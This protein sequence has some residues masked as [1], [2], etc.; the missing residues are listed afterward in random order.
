NAANR[1]RKFAYVLTSGVRP[2]YVIKRLRHRGDRA[3]VAGNLQ[4]ALSDQKF[5]GTVHAA[6]HHLCHLASAFLV[7]PHDKAVAVSVDGFGDF[8]SA[9]W[10]LGEGGRLSVD[11]RVYFPHSLG[12]FYEAMTQFIGFPHYGDE[13]KVMGLAP[14]GEPKFVREMSGLVEI[15]NN[16]KFKLDLRYFQHHTTNVSY[17]WNNCAPEVGKLYRDEMAELLGPPRNPEEPLEQRHK[18][19]ARSAQIVYEEAFFALLLALHRRYPVPN[20]ALSGGCA[21]NS[22]ANGKVYLRT[23]FRKMYLPAA[24]GDD[25]GAIGAA[26]MVAAQLGGTIEGPKDSI[27][28]RRGPLEDGR[29]KIEDGDRSNSQHPSSNSDL[30]SGSDLR[31]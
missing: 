25:G 23:P 19:L 13:Y 14:Y 3:D 12:V 1:W 26:A 16:G 9:A 30:P 2:S 20:L 27:R 4:R 7:S 5:T 22:V 8:S 24:A 29:S 17:S 18:D 31:D 28:T 11:G 6:E 10:G 21:M 15:T